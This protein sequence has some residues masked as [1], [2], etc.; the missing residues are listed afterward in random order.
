MVPNRAKHLVFSF[1]NYLI[2]EYGKVLLTQSY[3]FIIISNYLPGY[4]KQTIF[5]LEFNLLSDTLKCLLCKTRSF[6]VGKYLFKVNNKDTGATS[7]EDI[8]MSYYLL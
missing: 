4:V 3:G 1:G 6:P 8:P 2:A 5:V 7:I